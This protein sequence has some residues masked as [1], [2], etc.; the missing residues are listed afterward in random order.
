[1]ATTPLTDA[2]VRALK[3]QEAPYK[4]SDGGGLH[5]L[6]GVS[7][8]KTWRLAYRHAGKQRMLTIGPYPKVGSVRLEG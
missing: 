7:G 8:S 1:M 2:A 3:P 6:V 4:V 5:V